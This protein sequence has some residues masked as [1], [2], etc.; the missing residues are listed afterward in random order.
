MRNLSV[1]EM[2]YNCSVSKEV[3]AHQY[4]LRR[5]RFILRSDGVK[6]N[7]TPPLLANRVYLKTQTIG[8]D[9]RAK[10]LEQLLL[11]VVGLLTMLKVSADQEICRYSAFSVN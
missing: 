11:L 10:C 5:F 9:I 1:R 2:W 7:K 4:N 6:E 3:K 8:W